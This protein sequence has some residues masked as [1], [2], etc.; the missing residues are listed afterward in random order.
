M[1]LGAPEGIP[2]EFLIEWAIGHFFRNFSSLETAMTYWITVAIDPLHP[3]YGHVAIRDTNFMHKIKL[4]DFLVKKK[5]SF[6]ADW[7]SHRKT[8]NIINDTR[9]RLTHGAIEIHKCS[10]DDIDYIEITMTS[11]DGL[12]SEERKKY[13]FWNLNDMCIKIFM[14][15]HVFMNE[16][17]SHE[18]NFNMKRR[19]IRRYEAGEDRCSLATRRLPR[20]HLN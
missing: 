13:E 2:K 20:S 3:I 15:T 5:M 16:A 7:K 4:V 12:Y 1:R 18:K 10:I 8:L 9:N 6:N 14:L 17:E 19:E 11:A